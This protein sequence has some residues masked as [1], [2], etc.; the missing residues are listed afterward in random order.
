MNKQD[1]TESQAAEQDMANSDQAKYED[2]FLEQKLHAI[3]G[4]GLVLEE[5]NESDDGDQLELDSQ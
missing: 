3:Q 4:S 2:D 1:E 5:A